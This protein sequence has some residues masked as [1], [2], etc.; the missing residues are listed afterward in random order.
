[1]S[2]DVESIVNQ[3][4]T[5]VNTL[6]T[7]ALSASSLALA[8][9]QAIENQTPGFIGFNPAPYTPEPITIEATA[10]DSPDLDSQLAALVQSDIEDVQIADIALNVQPLPDDIRNWIPTPV[11]YVEGIYSST[12]LDALKAKLESDVENGSIGLTASVEQDIIDRN[13]ERDAQIWRDARDKVTAQWATSGFIIPD[14]VLVSAIQELIAKEANA[15]TDRSRDIRI[16]SFKMATENTRFVVQQGIVLESQLMN[17]FNQVADRAIRFVLAS[18]ETGMR[19]Y[20]GL[21]EAYKVQNEVALMDMQTQT[22]IER[23]KIE[24]LQAKLLKYKTDADVAVVK[25]KALIDKYQVDVSAYSAELGKAEA[26][27]R[28]TVSQQSMVAQHYLGALNL[29]MDAARTNLSNFTAITNIK[30]GAA[31]AMGNIYANYLASAINSLSAVVQAAATE[32]RTG[33]IT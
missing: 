22:A 31:T 15:N 4:I 8:N 28:V 7:Q 20:L 6:I 17:H 24:Q 14:N 3:K 32:T 9:L 19:I 18:A 33:S 29:S 21:V 13:T 1:M 16:D 11:D 5:T 2:I 27:A 23:L 12:L 25:I 10:P 26:L 30:T